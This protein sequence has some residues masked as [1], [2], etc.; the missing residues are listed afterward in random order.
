MGAETRF[1]PL[2]FDVPLD[3]AGSPLVPLAVDELLMQRL[4]LVLR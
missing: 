3:G 4:L 1:Q 2:V